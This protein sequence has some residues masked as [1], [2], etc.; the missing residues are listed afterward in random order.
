MTVVLSL[1]NP[2][3]CYFPVPKAIAGQLKK[4]NQKQKKVQLTPNR[5]SFNFLA[6]LP[7]LSGNTNAAK[8]KSFAA[9]DAVFAF[10]RRSQEK[11][12]LP[13]GTDNEHIVI[14]EALV[15]L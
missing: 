10:A 1:E 6:D 3:Q 12:A 14:Q 13:E 9:I 8:L 5:S 15:H 11:C 7:H 4:E 2:M